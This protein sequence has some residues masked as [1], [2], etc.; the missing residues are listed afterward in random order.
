L[1]CS[2]FISNRQDFDLSK[3]GRDVCELRPG[4]SHAQAAEY[5]RKARDELKNMFDENAALDDANMDLGALNAALE[6]AEAMG[7]A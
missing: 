1:L 6:H 5:G 3:D 4:M 2:L 7:G